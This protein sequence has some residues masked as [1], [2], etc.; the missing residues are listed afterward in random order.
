MTTVCIIRSTEQ[1]AWIK[2]VL[3][4]TVN[5]GDKLYLLQCHDGLNIAPM[6]EELLSNVEY[7]VEYK[8]ESLSGDCTNETV[9]DALLKIEADRICLKI[10]DRTNTGKV[11]IDDLTESILLHEQISGDVLIGDCAVV[12][13]NLTYS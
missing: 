10:S 6:M 8:I 7:A 4:S 2:E 5:S 12:L 3:E 9:I 1:H 11:Q 13:N